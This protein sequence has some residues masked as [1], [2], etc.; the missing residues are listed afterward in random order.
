MQH[1]KKNTRLPVLRKVSVEA[2]EQLFAA[3]NHGNFG[4]G[5]VFGGRCAAREPSP[6]QIE[7]LN[8]RGAN[9]YNHS[10]IDPIIVRGNANVHPNHLVIRKDF[11]M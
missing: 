10:Q 2:K 9:A 5:G 1:V 3:I 6:R 8:P 4:N 11:H 7:A